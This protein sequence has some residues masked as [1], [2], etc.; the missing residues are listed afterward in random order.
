MSVRIPIEQLTN[1]QKNKIS[2]DLNVE[3]VSNRYGAGGKT[4][5]NKKAISFYFA[6]N[7][8]VYLPFSYA[9]E[10]IS[11]YK[12]KG[13]FPNREA[14]AISGSFDMV[15]G[16]LP[17]DY[18]LEALRYAN[19]DFERSST[20]FFNV[21]CSFGKT[22]VSVLKAS[23]FSHLTG[24]ASL[25]LVPQDGV[26]ESWI[27]AFLTYSTARVA[28]AGQEDDDTQVIVC[29]CHQIDKL[30]EASKSRIGFLIID[31]ADC[32]CTPGHVKTLLATQPYFILACTATYERDDGMEE[33]IDLL[34]GRTRIVKIST[35][36][37]FV[38][39]INTP[40]TATDVA[41][42][43]FGIQVS[44]LVKKITMQEERNFLI[45]NI[46][47]L[48]VEKEKLLILTSLVEHA[49]HLFQM[50]GEYFD[51]LYK[52]DDSSSNATTSTSNKKRK[53]T[54]SRYFD[55]DKSYYD[56]DVLVGTFSKMG[57][58]FD[59]AAKA[60]GWDGRRFNMVI[61]ASTTMKIEQLSGRG[62]RADIPVIVE[63]VDKHVN[64]KK[65]WQVREPWYQSRNGIIVDV[66]YMP[67]WAEIWK[68]PAIQ[69][70]YEEAKKRTKEIGDNTIR[71]Y[72]KKSLDKQKMKFEE[73]V[74]HDSIFEEA[75]TLFNK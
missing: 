34:I 19:E 29:P 26:V 71:A 74:K 12:D 3:T 36:P 54:V 65:H 6:D 73:T 9:Y 14:K 47:E 5:S 27:G 35:K 51:Y 58:G 13:V 61:L 64:I 63:L 33:M 53:Y 16:F 57:R 43:K 21:F 11:G 60:K 7:Q 28:L 55:D 30:S 1:E 17:R 41:K 40:F 69:K 32:Y 56:S 4:F 70:M 10:N 66:G 42:T 50:I 22:I 67:C 49:N 24:T 31:E 39:K 62:F 44:D 37:F 48:N 72:S 52:R 75:M 45:L 25:V 68:T 23:E 2:R 38:L 8:Y 18:Q 46:V 15:E 59:Q 20:A